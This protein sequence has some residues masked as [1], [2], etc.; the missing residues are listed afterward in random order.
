MADRAPSSAIQLLG[1]LAQRQ[2]DASRFTELETAVVGVFDQ[3]RGRILRYSLSFGLP[4]ADAE[5]ILQ[6]V[7]LALYQHLSAGKPREV[8]CSWLFRVAHNLSLKRRL[9]NARSSGDP[10]LAPEPAGRAIEIADP[11]PNPED[12]FAFRQ[13]QSHLRAVV[14]ALPEIDR[15]CL[16]LR[17]EGLRYREIAE[18]LEISLGSVANSMAKSLAR[19]AAAD[20]RLK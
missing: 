8:S 9:A 12:Q 10:A 15:A 1:R 18:V 5:E 3:M 11:R 19:L 14:A 13:R 16:Y 17:A 20:E 7:F 4:V 2:R 6:E